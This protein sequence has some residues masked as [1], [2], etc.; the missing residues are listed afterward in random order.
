MFKLKRFLFAKIVISAIII[1]IVENCSK[2][3]NSFLPYVRVNL[4][5]PLANFNHLKIPGNSVL[6][7]N[8]GYKGIIVV[9]VDPN[10]S[11]YCAYDATCSYEKD[12]SGVIV[13]QPVKNLP[14]PPLTVFSSDFFG[15]C[16]KCGSKFNLMGNGQP[17]EGPSTRYLQSYNIV[18]GF[19][20]LTVTN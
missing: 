11:Q 12:F 5:I 19:E 10:A 6:F 17:V 14:S 3:Q 1:L 9:C 8:E 15:I 7:L 20:N 13:I 4:Y 2:D 16:N 18:T